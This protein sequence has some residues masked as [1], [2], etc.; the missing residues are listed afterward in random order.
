MPK[1]VQSVTFA[2]VCTGGG[3]SSFNFS[4][5]LEAHA[6][7]GSVF[8]H[9]MKVTGTDPVGFSADVTGSDDGDFAY[10]YY[11]EKTS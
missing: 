2:F 7:D 1:N 3:R 9:S 10:A 5:A 6:C 4:A 8:Q 11:A